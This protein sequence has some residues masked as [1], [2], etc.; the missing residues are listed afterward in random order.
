MPTQRNKKVAEGFEVMFLQAQAKLF[1]R[2]FKSED[3]L[4]EHLKTTKMTEAPISFR[5]ADGSMVGRATLQHIHHR[6]FDE[7]H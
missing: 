6:F 3:E 1:K 4:V 2:R 7:E 5:Y